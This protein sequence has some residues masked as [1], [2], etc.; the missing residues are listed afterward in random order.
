MLCKLNIPVA[1]SVFNSSGE[2]T[3]D[4]GH[5]QK[6]NLCWTLHSWC[7]LKRFFVR[8]RD[9]TH[10]RSES[11]RS[12]AGAA[13]RGQCCHGDRGRG[14]RDGQP[15]PAATATT[16]GRGP[17]QGSPPPPHRRGQGAPGPRPGTP[18]GAVPRCGAVPGPGRCRPP[19]S[20][21]KAP[22]GSPARRPAGGG[23]RCPT[24]GSLFS[25]S[26]RLRRGGGERCRRLPARPRAAGEQ[27]SAGRAPSPPPPR[28]ARRLRG[29][30]ERA[31]RRGP[32]SRPGCGGRER[33]P[34]PAPAHKGEARNRARTG[35]RTRR[36]GGSVPPRGGSG[37]G[38]TVTAGRRRG[39]CPGILP[40]KASGLFPPFPGER[41]RQRRPGCWAGWRRA[42]PWG[43]ALRP[44]SRRAPSAQPGR[45]AGCGPD[46]AAPQPLSAA[47]RGSSHL[48]APSSAI[49]AGMGCFCAVPEEF[50]CEVLLLDES[51]LTLTTQQQ[52]I[53]VRTRRAA[54]SRCGRARGA[55][56]RRLPLDCAA[57]AGKGAAAE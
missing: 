40:K 9:K 8:R 15:C 20:A 17:G 33:F 1:S 37:V 55:A 12:G 35:R 25:P 28:S 10:S 4:L 13:R 51:K 43:W 29:R 32:P 26:L 49:A 56:R 41:A 31:G 45:G 14:R 50:Y 18:V 11:R 57:I 39:L 23:R 48:L 2:K 3:S 7:L 47:A 22:P 36:V 24:A 27:R 30:R 46:P 42:A 38:A 34:G 21:P 6:F 52:G 53:K 16:E 54:E 44:S 5:F 19:L